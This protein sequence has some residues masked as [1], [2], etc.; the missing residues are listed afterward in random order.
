MSEDF[1]TFE[2]SS[3]QPAENL[4]NAVVF[5]VNTEFAQRILATLGELPGIPS[6]HDVK[7]LDK[8]FAENSDPSPAEVFASY[9]GSHSPDSD[10]VVG[11]FD[12]ENDQALTSTQVKILDAY[13][14]A[15]AAEMDE[16]A[17]YLR[18]LTPIKTQSGFAQCLVK[19]HLNE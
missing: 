19:Y 7:R 2:S 6:T 9:T 11:A 14:K 5:G 16:S 15:L 3:F 8:L 18:S 10:R 12:P 4:D 1:N 17:E 13:E